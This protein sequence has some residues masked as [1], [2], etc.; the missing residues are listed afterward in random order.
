MYE[1]VS[2]I[3]DAHYLEQA[4]APSISEMI[5]VPKQS[6]RQSESKPAKVLGRSGMI[7]SQQQ[8]NEA[9]RRRGANLR[10]LDENAHELMLC[11]EKTLWTQVDLRV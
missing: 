8:V 2:I 10:W 7:V 5:I 4:I 3:E 9:K 11:V 6:H 1:N